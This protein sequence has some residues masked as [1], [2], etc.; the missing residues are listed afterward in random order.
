MHAASDKNRGSRKVESPPPEQ[1]RRTEEEQ[2]PTVPAP[3]SIPP[4]QHEPT[5]GI[6]VPSDSA[7]DI[8]SA[9]IRSGEPSFPDSTL[10]RI[11]SQDPSAAPIRPRPAFSEDDALVPVAHRPHFGIGIGSGMV[12]SGDL[13]GM[14][15]FYLSWSPSSEGNVAVSGYVAFQDIPLQKTSA[16]NASLDGGLF[17]AG[18]GADMRWYRTPHYTFIGH[19]LSAGVGLYGLFWEYKNEIELPTYDED[20]NFKGYERIKRDV[21]GALDLHGGIGFDL[22]QVWHVNLEGEIS[23][24]LVFGLGRTLNDCDNDVFKPFFY[25]KMRVAVR[26]ATPF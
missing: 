23:P 1:R 22:G 21:L 25:L 4:P 11:S 9:L 26:F 15:E 24:G 8:R 7:A 10:E 5:R 12:S 17:F 16:L 6:P 14:S 18:V 13:F 20:G 19:Y 3:V 2:T